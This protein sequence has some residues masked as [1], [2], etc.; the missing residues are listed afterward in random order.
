MYLGVAVDL[1]VGSIN[2]TTWGLG[3]TIMEREK[4][5]ANV[6]LY[7]DLLDENFED[8][9][10]MLPKISLWITCLKEENPVSDYIEKPWNG[11]WKYFETNDI[12]IVV[13]N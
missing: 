13:T 12:R 10:D 8:D 5:L 2:D 1:R 11:T 7:H 9:I 3:F 6:F 4:K